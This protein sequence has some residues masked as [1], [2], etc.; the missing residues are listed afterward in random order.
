M[1]Y[2]SKIDNWKRFEKNNLTIARNIS[3]IKEKEIHPA[4]I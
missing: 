4:Y 1:N 3:Y 2:P